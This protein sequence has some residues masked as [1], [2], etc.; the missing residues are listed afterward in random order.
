MDSDVVYIAE[1]LELHRDADEEGAGEHEGVPGGRG[2]PHQAQPAGRVAPHHG[3]AQ[4]QRALRRVSQPQRRR[5]LPGPRLARRFRFPRL[6][7][8]SVLVS[9]HRLN[10]CHSRKKIKGGSSF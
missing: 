2:P 1:V 10:F 7:R 6:V 4:R 8:P 9:D 5:R 3:V